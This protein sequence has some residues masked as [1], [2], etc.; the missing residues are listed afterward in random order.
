[1]KFGTVNI[2]HHVAM[3]ISTVALSVFFFNEHY[4]G[5]EVIGLILGVVSILLLD[6]EH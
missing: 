2:M 3:A 1:M 5:K 4:T 6:H